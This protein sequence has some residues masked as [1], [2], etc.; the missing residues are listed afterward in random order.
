MPE[1]EYGREPIK[2]KVP[3]VYRKPFHY[4]W[5]CD[6]SE[7]MQ[8][9]GKMDAVNSAMRR[10]V[11]EIRHFSHQES[12]KRAR[13]YMNTLKFSCKASWIY[14]DHIGIDSFEWTDLKPE[15]ITDL[16]HAFL[17]LADRLKPEGKEGG[18]MKSPSYPPVLVL[19]TDGYPTDNWRAG[20]ETLDSEPWAKSAVR[21]AIGL[22]GADLDVL[23]EFIGNR[24]PNINENVVPV[25]NSDLS[26]LAE[27]IVLKT[28]TYATKVRD[29]MPPG[30]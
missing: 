5:I 21:L 30:Y 26:R 19:I 23:R 9:N 13:F 11:E 10:A 3:G 20:L 17:K 22:D 1:T 4:I 25:K 16:G 28:T 6:C 27:A 2:T 18:I 12:N 29:R 7:S 24:T 8:D 14:K 15:G